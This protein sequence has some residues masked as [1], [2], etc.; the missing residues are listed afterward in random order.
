[1]RKS[2][3]LFILCLPL[4]LIMFLSSCTPVLNA[5]KYDSSASTP[6]KESIGFTTE[7]EPLET[8]DVKIYYGMPSSSIKAFVSNYE[9]LS[10]DKNVDGE[11]EFELVRNVY[12][13]TDKANKDLKEEVL[14]REKNTY[15]YYF[16]DSF[17]Y[18]KNYY[19][20][21]ITKDDL[22]D[23]QDGYGYIVYEWS[24]TNLEDS[25][26]I[27][28]CKT[29]NIYYTIDDNLITFKVAKQDN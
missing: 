26:Y 28:R 21:T 15:K 22:F 5:T 24:I 12:S 18:G 1:M 11:F 13:A 29:V 7:N 25:M 20:D 19:L 8:H 4:A 10:F 6:D 27:K 9:Y 23:N 17:I 2:F 16:S 3:K 14:V